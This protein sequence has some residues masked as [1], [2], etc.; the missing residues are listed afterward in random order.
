MTSAMI[1]AA[2]QHKG[3]ALVDIF[4]PCVTFN[5]VN[6]FRWF[7][8]NV[9]QLEDGYDPTDKQAA[10]RKAQEKEPYP[11]GI[12][13]RNPERTV[14]HENLATY[15]DSEKPLYRRSLDTGKLREL[16]DSYRH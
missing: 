6:N 1:K 15:R 4:Q 10:I 14:F 12:I 8:E 16:V 3:Y 13:Y 11:V 7:K 2:I 9:Y 5:K